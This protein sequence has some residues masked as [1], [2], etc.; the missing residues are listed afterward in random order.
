MRQTSGYAIVRMPTRL[1]AAYDESMRTHQAAEL[2]KRLCKKLSPRPRSA[3]RGV[4]RFPLMPLPP[5]DPDVLRAFEESGC[6]IRTDQAARRL[7]L[8][9]LGPDVPENDFDD[10]LLPDYSAASDVFALLDSR[11]DYEIVQVAREP[12]VQTGNTLGFDTGYWGGDHYSIICDSAVRPLWHPP[13]PECFDELA[14]QLQ[15]VNESFLFPSAESAAT[16]RSWYRTQYWAET[17][18]RPDEFCIIQVNK[19]RA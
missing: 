5:I 9:I 6:D 12:F 18:S 10:D 11:D 13:Q 14:R 19:P 3:Y 2:F 7:F 15:M 4:S 1:V 16:F 8:E 17:E